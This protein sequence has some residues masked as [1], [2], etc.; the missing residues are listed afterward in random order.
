MPSSTSQGTTL[1][2]TST[3]GLKVDTIVVKDMQ[4][5]NLRNKFV[6]ERREEDVVTAI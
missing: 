3:L 1:V 2:L 5:W 4:D 6:F